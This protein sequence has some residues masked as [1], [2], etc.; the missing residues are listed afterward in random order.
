MLHEVAGFLDDVRAERKRMKREG[1]AKHEL[2]AVS[3]V[4]ADLSGSLNRL[5]PMAQRAAEPDTGT[6][7]D[8]MPA[9]L[10]AYR[11]ALARKIEAFMASR[12]DE[13][14]AFELDADGS[15]DA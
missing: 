1:Y 4:I 10:D 9:D 12:G 6:F 11:E 7:Y 5:K 15:G 3:R 13:A 14:D 2:R 8:D